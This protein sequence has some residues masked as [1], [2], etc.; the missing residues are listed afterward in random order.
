MFSAMGACGLNFADP[1][2]LQLKP[3]FTLANS[4]YAL[5]A[6]FK[7]G[8]L[9]FSLS[10]FRGRFP[11]PRIG[12]FKAVLGYLGRYVSVWVRGGRGRSPTAGMRRGWLR[13]CKV[14]FR[15]KAGRPVRFG[16]T[17][18]MGVDRCVP[19]LGTRGPGSGRRACG[20]GIGGRAGGATPVRVLVVGEGQAVVIVWW[21]L[22]RGDGRRGRR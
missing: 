11:F 21:T 5:R 15:Q 6:Q 12:T 2:V 9:D 20:A 1:E 19:G 18:G 7:L 13:P 14:R 3:E 22:G 16:E 4:Q 10:Y 8:E 17:E